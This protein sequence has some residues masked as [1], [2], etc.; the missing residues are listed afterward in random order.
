MRARSGAPVPTKRNGPQLRA[1]SH[2]LV[3]G[4]CS[5]A[6]RELE[7]TDARAPVERAV[8][9]QIL[10]RVPE[11]AIVDR[12]DRHGTVVAPTIQV[13]CLAAGAGYQRCLCL[14]QRV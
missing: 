9:G 5:V 12:I 2:S 1:V 6:A 7:R 14:A 11:R 8:R 13:A 3:T 10:G 4:R